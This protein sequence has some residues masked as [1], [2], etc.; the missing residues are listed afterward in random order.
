[1]IKSDIF[2]EDIFIYTLKFVI[3]N[4]FLYL[5]DI[6]IVMIVILNVIIL[7]LL[8]FN[9]NFF[10]YILY[11]YVNREVNGIAKV[12]EFYHEINYIVILIYI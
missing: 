12:D 6:D 1:M 5:L 7:I 4:I 2:F 11:H 10:I 3:F 9:L 8:K